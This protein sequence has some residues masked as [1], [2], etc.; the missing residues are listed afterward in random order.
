MGDWF[1]EP[2][3][4]FDPDTGEKSTLFKVMCP[5]PKTWPGGQPWRGTGCWGNAYRVACYSDKSAAEEH[6]RTHRKPYGYG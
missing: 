6:A 4:Y 5:T 3:T 1:V 2:Y